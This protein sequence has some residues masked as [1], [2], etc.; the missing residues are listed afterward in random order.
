MTSPPSR[1]DIVFVHIPKT[2][3]TSVRFALTEQA[4]RRRVLL[5]YG[6]GPNTSPEMREI[7]NDPARTGA[8]HAHMAAPHGLLLM[9]HFPAR[10]YWDSFNS[11]S[12]VTFVRDP[13]ARVVSAYNHHFKR[14]RYGG[15]LLSFAQQPRHRNQLSRFIGDLWPRFGFLGLTESYEAD[16]AALSR[17]LGIDLPV[18]WRNR[19]TAAPALKQGVAPEVL[20]ALREINAADV[21]LYAAI[22]AARAAAEGGGTLPPPGPPPRGRVAPEQ[23]GRFAGWC[24]DPEAARTWTVSVRLD[25]EEIARLRADR[26]APRLREQGMSRTGIGRFVFDAAPVAARLAAAGRQAMLDFAIAE[27]DGAGRIE[28][29]PFPIGAAAAPALP[30]E[31]QAPQAGPAQ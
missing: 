17:H 11:D 30:A 9:G 10:R 25:G 1:R 6:R 7:W 8:L 18:E 21:A 20:D 28:G 19:G 31:G 3:G 13:V 27:G 2:A 14:N 5:D 24:A 22:R 26:H 12:F 29:G 4:G 15:D 16:L 23:A